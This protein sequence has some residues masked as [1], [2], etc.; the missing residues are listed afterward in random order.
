VDPLLVG[1]LVALL[2]VCAFW[3]Y[4]SYRRHSQAAEARRL[5]ALNRLLA[6]ADELQQQKLR[7]QGIE[8]EPS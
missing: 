5:A 6:E 4:R 7:D 8:P 2:L 3:A 1:L